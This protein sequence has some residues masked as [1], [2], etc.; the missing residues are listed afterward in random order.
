MQSKQHIWTVISILLLIC[1]VTGIRGRFW[2]RAGDAEGPYGLKITDSSWSFRCESALCDSKWE[3]LTQPKLQLSGAGQLLL[4]KNTLPDQ[5]PHDA[6]I[7]LLSNS[8]HG[9][10]K[11]YVNESP[12]YEYGG[13]QSWISRQYLS[14]SSHCIPLPDNSGGKPILFEFKSGPFEA[15]GFSEFPF[16]GS[17]NQWNVRAFQQELPIAI[18]RMLMICSGLYCL[19]VIAV[20]DQ[21]NRRTFVQIGTIAILTGINMLDSEVLGTRN[22]APWLIWYL[23]NGSMYLLPVAFLA[24][25][26]NLLGLERPNRVHQLSIVHQ[27]IAGILLLC[28][29]VVSSVLVLFFWIMMLVTLA[30]VAPLLWKFLKS[31]HKPTQSYIR[32]AFSLLLATACLDLSFVVLMLFGLSDISSRT[33]YLGMMAFLVL[34]GYKQTVQSIENRRELANKTRL[35]EAQSDEL[36]KH[37]D[38]L[39][40]LVDER[41]QSLRITSNALRVQKEKA[42]AANRAKSVFLASV[43]HELRTPLNGILGF[44]Q[45]IHRNPSVPSELK[46]Q[47]EVIHQCGDHLLRLINNILDLSRIESGKST[48]PQCPFPLKSSLDPLF[49][50]TETADANPST[51]SALGSLPPDVQHLI[52]SYADE[53]DV[54][55][56][57]DYLVNLAS[58]FPQHPGIHLL[59]KLARNCQIARIKALLHG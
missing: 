4:F 58:S 19:L 6:A 21:E 50:K 29:Q 44:T 36:K 25:I 5:L 52:R 3:P 9:P 35:L 2:T 18:I 49:R 51:D 56:L 23:T 32:W 54:A 37:R 41:T 45:I 42:E 14:S 8:A 43:S 28:P 10:F 31:K 53:G 24:Y 39:E 34:V 26:E 15:S 27:W 1:V 11:V 38:N 33:F 22:P 20:Y 30:L 7:I 55:T 40:R 13:N 12:I 47:I 48:I 46:S 16:F 59:L 17:V 57:A